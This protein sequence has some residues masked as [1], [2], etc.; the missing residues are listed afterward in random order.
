MDAERWA[1]GVV[2][3][4]L[5]FIVGISVDLYVFKETKSYEMDKMMTEFSKEF[6]IGEPVYSKVRMSIDSCEYLW[7]KHYPKK[8]KY[9]YEQINAYL[10]FFESL[11]FLYENK[12]VDLK[13]IDHFFGSVILEAHTYP[14]IEEYIN[15]YKTG[16]QKGAFEKFTLLA[17]ALINNVPGRK[18]QAQ[19]IKNRCQGKA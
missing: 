11:G 13:T 19:E 17:N 12:I 15:L 1:I 2:G 9:N 10:G 18:K 16:P 3:S 4:F 8:G 5:G 6:Y 14:E 7:D